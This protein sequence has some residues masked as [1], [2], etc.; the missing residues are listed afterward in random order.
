MSYPTASQLNQGSTQRMNNR[1]D[2]LHLE[3]WK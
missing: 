1:A 3:L 2:L